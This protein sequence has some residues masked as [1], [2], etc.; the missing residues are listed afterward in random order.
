MGKKMRA[1]R[2]G[3][4]RKIWYLNAQ[5]YEIELGVQSNR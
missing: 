4:C 5:S 3:P 2:L 1:L